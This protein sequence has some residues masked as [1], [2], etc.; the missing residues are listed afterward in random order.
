MFEFFNL[1]YA[2]W[3]VLVSVAISMSGAFAY[4]RDIFR[5]KS[6]PNLVTWGL[7]AATPLIATGAALSADAD[8]W[9]TIRIFAA[10]LGPL[11]VFLAV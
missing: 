10:G 7:W 2:H 1:S 6:K 5:G 3:L 9:A 8:I 4:I 11:L